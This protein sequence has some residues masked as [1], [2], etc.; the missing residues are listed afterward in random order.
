MSNSIKANKEKN[1][2]MRAGQALM[3]PGPRSKKSRQ[4]NRLAGPIFWW[5][6]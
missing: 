3:H 2:A 6:T 4:E 5:P 1:P